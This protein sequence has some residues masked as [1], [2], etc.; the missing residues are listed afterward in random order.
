MP[1]AIKSMAL[2]LLIIIALAGS[3][4]VPAI[5]P[6]GPQPAGTASPNAASHLL[7]LLDNAD[8][9]IRSAAALQLNNLPGDALPAIEAALKEG[10][11][12]VESQLRLQ[13]A[14]RI[15]GPRARHEARTLERRKWEGQ[16]LH[17]AYLKSGQTD[18]RFDALAISAI[19]LFRA[20]GPDPLRG[21]SEPRAKAIAAFRAALA[22]GC[23]DPFVLC[24]FHLAVGEN[25]H[26]GQGPVPKPFD[27]VFNEFR[28]GNY[29]AAVKFYVLCRYIEAAAPFDLEL[30]KIPITLLPEIAATPGLPQGELDALAER[31]YSVLQT[32]DG[33]DHQ[34]LFPPF[35]KAYMVL[36]PGKAGPRI[37]QASAIIDAAWQA[38]GSA[39]AARVAPDAW[40]A[41]HDGLTEAERVLEETWRTDSTEARVATLMITVKMGQGEEGG[42]REAMETWFKRAMEADPD[43][44]DACSR[45]LYYLYPRWHGSHEEMIEF[46]REC[47]NTANWRAGLPHLLVQAHDAI[48]QESTDTAEYYQRPDVWRDI[49]DVYEG[50]LLNFPD[51]VYHRSQYAK[52]AA[53]CGKWQVANKQFTILGDKA[54]LSVF[55]SNASLEYLRKKAARLG[56]AAPESTP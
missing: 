48:A 10:T 8:F 15:L 25:F 56:E 29:P 33:G 23:D 45:K 35:L 12:S 2:C 39:I 36:S 46:G 20:L 31:F 51:D 42:G 16:L 6:S 22:R 37:L 11:F 21:P 38:R 28:T 50:N 40:K 17:D 9:R 19:D 18:P 26:A 5:E 52:A 43:N 53:R 44:Y 14:L 49:Q 27:Q 41:F 54:Q 1:G 32:S 55:G 34:H 24:L 3:A 47:L 7:D 30:R 13:A 4:A